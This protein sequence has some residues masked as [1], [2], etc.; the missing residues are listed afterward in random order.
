MSTEAMSQLTALLAAHGVYALTI[1]F[2]FYQQRRTYKDFKG[3]NEENRAFLMTIYK[4]SVVAT[5]VL[6]ALSTAA[7]GYSTFRRPPYVWVD[8]AIDGVKNAVTRP[9]KPRDPPLVVQS[10]APEGGSLNRFMSEKVNC[11][12]NTGLCQLSWVLKTRSDVASIG[13]KFF[14]TYTIAKLRPSASDPHK[15]ADDTVVEHGAV[16]SRFTI[17]PSAMGLSAGRELSLRYV[18]NDDAKLIGTL[19]TR[20]ANLQWMA[21]PWDTLPAPPAARQQP[22]PIGWRFSPARLFTLFAAEVGAKGPFGADGQYQEDFGRNL[23]SWLGGPTVALQQTGVQI[24][25]DG[26]ARAFKFIADSQSAKLPADVNKSVLTSNLMRAV[27]EIE[28]RGTPLPTDLVESLAVASSRNGNYESSAR[29]FDKV[30]D[31]PLGKVESYFYRGLAYRET[32]RYT[33]AI[34]DLERYARETPSAYSKAV[35]YTS[36]GISYRRS[37]NT[38]KAVSYYELAIKAYPK[39]AGPYNALAYLQALD[40][41]RRDFTEALALVD[42]ALTLRPGDPNYLDTRGWVLFRMQRYEEAKTLLEM[43]SKELPDDAEVEEHL[44]QVTRAIGQSKQRG[45]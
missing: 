25:V 34:D 3:A 17:D 27:V 30:R 29:F 19:Y 32:A 1:L 13:F 42:K 11:E 43:A 31:K 4:S 2:I 20:G 6:A 5:Y 33:E 7:W 37:K 10:I 41:K 8:G 36:I 45:R 9:E 12:I 16:D 28:A 39:Y 15:G 14:H 38:T 35:A 26:R 21:L 22:E 24:L 40:P 23:R 18:Q 44:E